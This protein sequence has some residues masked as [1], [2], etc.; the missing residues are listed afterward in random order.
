MGVSG[1]LIESVSPFLDTAFIDPED[2]I[3]N[4]KDVRK[5]AKRKNRTS[6]EDEH[7]V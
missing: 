7:L 5:V 1:H 4:K 2:T 3:E 6:D